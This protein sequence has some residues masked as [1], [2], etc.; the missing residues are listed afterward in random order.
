MPE[1]GVTTVQSDRAED[2]TVLRDAGTGRDNRRP[3]TVKFPAA[4]DADVEDVIR[5]LDVWSGA[6]AQPAPKNKRG[7]R[8]RQQLIESATRAFVRQ[9]FVDCSVEDII[10][11]AEKAVFAAIIGQSIEGRLTATDVSHVDVPLVRDRI[12]LSVRLFLDSFHRAQG[13]S[14]VIEQ[15]AYHDPSFRRIRLIIRDSFA[16]RIAKGIRRQQARGIAD[17]EIDP[18]EAGLA[19]VSMMTYYAQT[20]LGWRDRQ[21]SEEM[22]ELL[23]RFWVRGIGLQEDAP[24]SPN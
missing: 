18:A 24:V 8:T 17:A 20:E 14:M 7:E 21:P 11:E 12:E 4:V 15:A 5:A 6:T 3:P 10:Q 9:G 13:L 16:R 23:T 1:L 19:I 2:G 22:V